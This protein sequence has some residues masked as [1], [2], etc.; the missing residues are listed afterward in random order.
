MD[1]YSSSVNGPLKEEG[2]IFLFAERINDNDGVWHYFSSRHLVPLW[3]KWAHFMLQRAVWIPKWARIV[4]RPGAMFAHGQ[5]TIVRSENLTENV[6]ITGNK[7]YPRVHITANQFDGWHVFVWNVLLG[8]EF[9]KGVPGSWLWRL[10]EGHIKPCLSYWSNESFH[11]LS[12]SRLLAN[13][14]LAPHE[15]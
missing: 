6:K 13:C 3:P 4:T 5:P 8:E 14:P 2:C 15:L 1:R 10:L 7:S 11:I 12:T 9:S